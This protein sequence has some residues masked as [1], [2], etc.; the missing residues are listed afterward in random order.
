[1]LSRRGSTETQDIGSGDPEGHQTRAG[2]YNA[3][4]HHHIFGRSLGVVAVHT[5]DAQGFL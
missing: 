2:D 3:R 4:A 5:A 1:M